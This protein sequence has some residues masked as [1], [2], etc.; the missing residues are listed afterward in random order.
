M[1]AGVIIGVGKIVVVDLKGLRSGFIGEL[2]T[3]APDC[4]AISNS[5][6]VVNISVNNSGGLTLGGL[7]I[8]S[9]VRVVSGSEVICEESVLSIKL[10]DSLLSAIIDPCGNILTG[11]DISSSSYRWT[12]ESPA[13]GIMERES[14]FE[15]LQSGLIAVDSMVPIGRGQRELVVGDRQTSKAS[16]GV[17]T[18]LNQ[19]Y[20]NVFCSYCPIG[21]KASAVLEVFLCLIRRDAVS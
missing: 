15:P 4:P 12:I 2:F 13:P 1:S 20:E 8:N 10:G 9:D 7:L 11:N 16:V 14:V 3:V 19:K 21:Q 6:M 17:D 5:G 18:I